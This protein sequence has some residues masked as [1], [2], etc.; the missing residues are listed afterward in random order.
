MNDFLRAPNLSGGAIV[1]K[2]Q[3][4]QIQYVWDCFSEGLWSSVTRHPKR[5]KVAPRLRTGKRGHN[6]TSTSPF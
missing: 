3:H 4:G 6:P 5:T 2:V 1:R